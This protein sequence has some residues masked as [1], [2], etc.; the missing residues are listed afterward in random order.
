MS[1]ELEQQSKAA[2]EKAAES[3]QLVIEKVDVQAV[4]TP[5]STVDFISYAEKMAVEDAKKELS[6]FMI[7]F[8]NIKTL[9]TR[10]L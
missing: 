6:F 5:M 9:F 2:V 10:V 8:K 7:F 3:K 4:P 1:N